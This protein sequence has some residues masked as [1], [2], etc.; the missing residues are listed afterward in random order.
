VR[1]ANSLGTHAE[2]ARTL[3]YGILRRDR[4]EGRGFELRALTTASSQIAVNSNS[5]AERCA[6]LG[7]RLVAKHR[8]RH[9]V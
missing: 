5:I 3:A 2:S 6:T 4:E 8:E 9:G 7:E 1:D